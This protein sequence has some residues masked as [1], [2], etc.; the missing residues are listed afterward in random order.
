MKYIPYLL[1]TLLFLLTVA[2]CEDVIDINLAEHETQLVVDAWI[3][4][5]PEQQVITLHRTSP[6]FDSNEPPAVTGA[7]VTVIDSL[8]GELFPF[9]DENNNG[10]Y[11]W[12]PAE[13]ETF[14]EIGHT[15]VL[16]IEVDGQEYGSLSKLNRVMPIDS[17]VY[18]ERE[19]ELGFPAGIY[20]EVFARDLVG[21]GDAYW[22]KAYKNGQFLNKPDEI[23]LAYD[24]AFSV[25]SGVDGITLIPPIRE[26]INRSPD[27]G[28]G[29]TDTDDLPPYA[30]GDSV[31]VEIHSLTLEAFLFLQLAFFQMTLGDAGIFATPPT[32][33]PSNILNLDENAT[34]RQQ[35]LGFFCV[36]AVSSEGIIIE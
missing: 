2:G 20:A 17:I 10:R 4:D 30:I 32:N 24:A 33:V 14:G 25:G 15:Y 29:A 21:V 8:T 22:I 3:N 9:T 23:T 31:Y 18:E 26:N 6:Y 16:L 11:I 36:S 5:K 1:F 27:D 19:E 7:T 34:D 12:T 35:P 13:G 28:E